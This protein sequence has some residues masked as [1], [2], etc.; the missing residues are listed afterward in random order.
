MPWHV[1][2]RAAPRPKL[3]PVGLFI[4]ALA[5]LYTHLWLA[6][7]VAA[8]LPL[9]WTPVIIDG[10]SMAPTLNRGDAAAV[11]PATIPD[12]DIG[13]VVTFTQNGGLVTHRVH[14]AEPDAVTTK[15]DANPLADRSPVT[16]ENLVGQVRYVVPLA[17]WPWAVWQRGEFGWLA[18]WL[19]ATAAAGWRAARGLPQPAEDDFTVATTE[20]RP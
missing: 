19:A 12:L 6:A 3:G 16:D 11:S 15:G 8:A 2:K 17:A 9:G 1:P 10:H 14:A 4:G 5:W 18:L 20:A 7:F 13:E